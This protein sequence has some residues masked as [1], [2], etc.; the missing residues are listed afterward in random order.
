MFSPMVDRPT[1]T[2]RAAKGD[3]GFS[4]GRPTELGATFHT[5]QEFPGIS[6][7]ILMRAPKSE[8]TH[9]IA[10]PENY[11]HCGFITS[12]GNLFGSWESQVILY[13]DRGHAENYIRDLKY[14]L[15]LLHYPRL[16]LS[17]NKAYGVLAGIS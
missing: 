16:K 17:A 5:Y 6:T 15:E 4:D 3:V 9:L 10:S 14:A 13:R 1:I 11:V 8:G 7:M 2:W 12:L